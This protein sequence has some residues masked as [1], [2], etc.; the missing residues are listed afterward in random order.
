MP[1]PELHDF[2]LRKAR[3]WSDL[4]TKFGAAGEGFVRINLACP[5]S[6]VDEALLR[7]AN[8]LLS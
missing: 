8:A 5:R 6:V 2:L 1:A 7:L 3:L 4:G